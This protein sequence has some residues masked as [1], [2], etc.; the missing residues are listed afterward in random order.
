MTFTIE[1]IAAILQGEIKGEQKEVIHSIAKIQE[2][3][4]GTISFLSNPKYE[5]YIYTTQASAVIVNKTFKPSQPI[6]TTLILVDDAYS[7]LGKLLEEY[8]KISLTPKEGIEQPSFISTT[9]KI[10]NKAYIG[11]FV[12]IGENVIIGDNV[13]IYPHTFIGDNVQIGAHSVLHTGVKVT[14]DCKIGEYCTIQPNAVIGS[15]GFGFAP[16]PDGTYKTV[17]QIGN[18]VIGNRVDIG[19]NTT[20]D[21]ATMGSTVIADGVKIDNLVQIAHNVEIGENTVFAAQ[22]G[23]SGSTKLGKNC[24]VAGQAGFVGHIEIADKT[25]I[26]AQSGILKSVEE[27]GTI[28]IGSPAFNIKEWYRSQAIFRKLPEMWKRLDAV[29]KKVNQN[30]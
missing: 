27:P 22:A 16:Q 13:K 8:Q 2:G 29:E 5:E 20:I 9:A 12:Y 25:T 3:T 18:V 15:D 1:Q 7:A 28:I 19:A 23:V 26:G 21:R 10:G 11:A 30:Q 14:K 6:H 17:P 4:K 24:V